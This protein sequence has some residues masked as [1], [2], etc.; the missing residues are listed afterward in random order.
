MEVTHNPGLLSK[1]VPRQTKV[2][3]TPNMIRYQYKNSKLL[4]VGINPHHGSFD[5]GI[6]FSNNKL[7]WYLLLRAGLIE[8]SM[9]DLRDDSELKK[10]YRNKFNQVYRLGLINIIERPTRDITLLKKGEEIKG[11][12]KI[13]RI[14]K[15]QK[16]KVVCFIG[17]VSYEKYIGSMNFTFGRQN[18]IRESKVY[19]MHFPLRGKAEIRINELKEL[20]QKL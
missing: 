2:H 7:F 18:D 16:P 4:F 10:I 15:T 5:R 8:E 1:G 14:I 12:L 19:V 13:E 3:K 6:P 9:D 17:K 11:R 20:A